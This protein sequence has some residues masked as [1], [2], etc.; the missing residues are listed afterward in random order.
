MTGLLFFTVAPLHALLVGRGLVH[1]TRAVMHRTRAEVALC[2]PQ[3]V[4]L[5][6][7][8]SRTLACAVAGTV[9]FEG[10]IYAAMSPREAPI[11]LARVEDENI[12]PV[13]E[14]E[15]RALLAPAQAACTDMGVTLVDSPFILTA[16]RAGLDK[17]M[18]ELGDYGGD[19]YDE[20]DDDVEEG[21]NGVEEDKEDEEDVLVLTRFAHEGGEF[22]VIQLEPIF[23]VGKQLE[24]EER[25]FVAPSDDE[26]DA[27]NPLIEEL[28]EK[29]QDQ[30]EA[31]L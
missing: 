30:E 31:G 29:Y 6:V 17:L 20:G 4:L 26:L 3:A 9:A 25:K 23:V 7:E 1:H 15:E 14:E 19:F 27:V 5:D 16:E 10:Q 21:V 2:E 22:C 28:L 24:G 13:D 11:A 12:A 8:S 18:L